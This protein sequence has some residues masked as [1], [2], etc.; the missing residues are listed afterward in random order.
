MHYSVTLVCIA[1]TDYVFTCNF[2]VFNREGNERLQEAWRRL[3]LVLDLK[4]G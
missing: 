1:T 2:L 4:T 3:H